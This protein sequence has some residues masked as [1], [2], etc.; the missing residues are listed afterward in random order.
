[1][2]KVR[3]RTS[4]TIQKAIELAEKAHKGQ[5]RAS[6]DPY[7]THPKAVMEILRKIHADEE[8][9]VAALLHDTVEDTALS[10][11]DVRVEFGAT[12]AR[13]VEGV[14]KVQQTEHDLPPNERGFAAI[15][16]IFQVM[17]SDI[18]V[19]FIKLADRLHNMQTLG[20]LRKDKQQRIARET[21]E[22]YVPICD[23][24]GIRAWY[25]E[26]SDLCLQHLDPSTHQLITQ[27][28][29]RAEGGGLRTLQEW[30]HHLQR[31]LRREGFLGVR[32][33]LHKR[34]FEEI[35]RRTE[36]QMP[37]LRLPETFYAVR[38]L[39]R[40]AKACYPL[41]GAVHAQ[42]VAL[43]DHFHD[44]IASSKINGYQALHT[45]VLSPL[46]D[47]IV[48]TVQSEEMH[49][50]GCYGMA[51]PYQW[52]QHERPWKALPQWVRKLLSIERATRGQAE[53]F[54]ALQEELFGERRT[55]H[56]AGRTVKTIDVPAMSTLLD[57][58]FHASP[59]VADRVTS[60]S[61]HGND[62]SLRSLVHA[63][64]VI[65]FRTGD[66]GLRSAH[67]LLTLRTSQGQKGLLHL[68]GRRNTRRRHHDGEKLLAD[69]LDIAIDP[70]LPTQLHRTLQQRMQR[71]PG[72]V[73]DIA[74]GVRNP[75]DVLLEHCKPEEIFLV[76]PH[77]FRLGAHLKPGQKM[78]FILQTEIEDLRSGNTIGIHT[79]PDVIDIIRVPKAKD[80]S[81]LD[82][83]KELVPL[84]VQRSD[85]LRHPFIFGLRWSFA[86][87]GEP[88]SVIARI[89][90]ILDTPVELTEFDRTS[91]TL[92]FHT[93]TINTLCTAYAFLI[94]D[95]GVEHIVR[96]S[97]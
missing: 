75:F 4:A 72:V 1:M 18:R 46:G 53:L 30:V 52:P 65:A 15:R 8:S 38:I 33:L 24:L 95:P 94:R 82:S 92:V 44:F 97:P 35:R 91:A 57:V 62:A 51:L 66:T 81:G 54:Q 86:K 27:K 17:G 70:F 34:C 83:S 19:I 85:L 28:Q 31:V 80:S 12:V 77:C 55:V 71:E 11:D 63:G 2:A 93:G 47:P 6:G 36:E 9:L 96:I 14:T 7:I 59:A 29:K 78:R 49:L 69:V 40:N 42:A 73:Q 23:L 61:V 41:L 43:P 26:L 10:T 56:L 13:L 88:L 67:D 20:Y 79:R 3:A 39:T 45:T 68:L 90:S 84:D 89:Q 16:K 58:A 25:E 64:D 32:V 5:K 22:I 60:A 50:M 76:D 87:G 21:L 48:I 37:L 74:T